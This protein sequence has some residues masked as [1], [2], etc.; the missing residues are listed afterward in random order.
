MKKMTALTLSIFALIALIAAPTIS[1]ASD[2]S[3]KA[4]TA[5]A[6]QIPAHC[7]GEQA[8][9]CAAKL[10]LSVEEC[11]K[12]CSADGHQFVNLSI[13][14]M[15]CVS[16]E[17]TITACL[18]EVPGVV[19][20]GKVSHT[21][22]TAFAVIDSKQVKAEMLAEAVTKK[23]YKAEVAPDEKRSGEAEATMVSDKKGCGTMT[24]KACAKTC[25][26]TCAAK[27]KSDAKT[28][29]VKES[30]TADESK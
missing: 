15:T 14:G 3:A 29:K 20:V 21:D 16:C 22:G 26:K 27:A 19:K 1:Y 18:E 28:D 13:E 11:Q 2:C 5:E 17:K 8:K 24:K 10:G 9:A 6:K 25:A 23:G 30:G 7:S 4:K 12:L